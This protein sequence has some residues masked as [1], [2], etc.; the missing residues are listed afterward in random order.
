[1]EGG[2]RCGEC[3]AA[4]MLPVLG[5]NPRESKC[6][7]NML[8]FSAAVC[9][10]VVLVPNWVLHIHQGQGCG[11]LRVLRSA[12]CSSHKLIATLQLHCMAVGHAA[13]RR[14]WCGPNWA[15]MWQGAAMYGRRRGGRVELV[16]PPWRPAAGPP[17]PT[18][19]PSCPT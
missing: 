8:C 3:R 19:H 15:G 4:V 13:C 7:E 17:W 12:L 1:M 10:Y 16:T 14:Q 6:R 18:N 2:G 9:S 11:T 5:Q